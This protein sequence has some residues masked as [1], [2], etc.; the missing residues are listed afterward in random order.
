LP[1]VA[2][3]AACIASS[4]SLAGPANGAA[5]LAG[6][7]A[8]REGEMSSRGLS[9]G[10]DAQFVFGDHWSFNPTIMLSAERESASRRISDGIAGLQL[11]RWM[12]D[13]FAGAHF[14]AHVRAI[15]VDNTITRTNYGPAG[16]VVAGF[17]RSSGWGAAIQIDA[18]ENT[19]VQGTFRNAVRL[20][21]TH[22]WH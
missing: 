3:V 2:L 12:G 18:F 1:W 9:I 15:V 19:N 17:E 6:G 4:A 13:W 21:L 11:R 10:A 16:G 20:H 7:I 14:F 8:A 22:R 5:V